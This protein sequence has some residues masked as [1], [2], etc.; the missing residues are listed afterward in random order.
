MHLYRLLCHVGEW[1]LH[2]KLDGVQELDHHVGNHL[3]AWL[4]LPARHHVA[5]DVESAEQVRLPSV[6]SRDYEVSSDVVLPGMLG[7]LGRLVMKYSVLKVSTSDI[8]F[9]DVPSLA[10]LHIPV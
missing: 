4:P 6:V 7:Q 5:S 9:S 1:N 10:P 3:E 2:G 8:G